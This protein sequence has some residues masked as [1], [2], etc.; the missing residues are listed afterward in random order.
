MSGLD[1]RIFQTWADLQS[2]LTTKGFVFSNGVMRWSYT[3]AAAACHWVY[4]SNGT[5]NFVDSANNQVFYHNL[6][7]FVN[8]KDC[9]CIFTDLTDHG[10]VLYLTPLDREFDIVDL[11]FCC[12]NNYT[13]EE[14]VIVDGDNPLENGLIIGSPPEQDGYWRYLWRDQDPLDF[15]FDVDNTRGVITKGTEIP[16]TKMIPAPLTVT[17]LKVYLDTGGW[18]SYIYTQVLGEITPPCNIFKING[19]KFISFSDNTEW[20]CPVFKLPPENVEQNPI[21][22]TDQFSPLRTYR[23][24]DYCV[25]EG[26]LWVCVQ[27]IN[28]PGPFDQ[29]YWEITTVDEEKVK[30]E[31]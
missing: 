17:L 21:G 14:E 15:Y 12:E 19:Q 5:M 24:N 26:K 4:D 18:S 31:N 8:N 3:P 10:F 13:K 29:S 20:R 6:T 23:V 30:T 1:K 25:W 7:D 11:Q 22:A 16:H 27:A 9:G 2:F 28:T